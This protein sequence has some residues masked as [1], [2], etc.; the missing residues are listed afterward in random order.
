[1]ELIERFHMDDCKLCNIAH[2]SHGNR[3]V[4][5]TV[6]CETENFMWTPGLGAFVEGYSL[7]LSKKHLLNTGALGNS[8]IEELQ[9]LIVKIKKFFQKVYKQKIILF[10]HGSV[11]DFHS[12]GCISHQHLHILP[13][14][15]SGVPEIL[16]KNFEYE[17][18]ND[19]K[20]LREYDQF[21]NPYL[22]YENTDE[23]KYVF[24]VDVCCNINLFIC[25][26][27]VKRTVG[28]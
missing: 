15:I 3:K 12:G 27:E 13:T 24:K 6:I 5:D 17:I 7:L 11:G 20:V 18:I 28:N 10:E 4:Q 19:I 8:A 16:L 26:D 25:M 9:G 14:D 2:N 23:S 22:Y 21:G 1:M